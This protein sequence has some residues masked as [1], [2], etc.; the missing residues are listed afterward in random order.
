[1]LQQERDFLQ[2]PIY[3]CVLPYQTLLLGL[4]FCILCLSPANWGFFSFIQEYAVWLEV[5]ERRLG[6]NEKSKK[7]NRDASGRVV[8]GELKTNGREV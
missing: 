3:N 8:G 6:L 1:M 5:M 4:K 2:E 7:R